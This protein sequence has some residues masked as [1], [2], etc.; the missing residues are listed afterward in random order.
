VEVQGIL[1]VDKLFYVMYIEKNVFKGDYLFVSFNCKGRN[2]EINI[3][4]R[5]LVFTLEVCPFTI[6]LL[7]I[8]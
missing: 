5:I 7:N 8:R 6:Q 1:D 2:C 3:A 4:G